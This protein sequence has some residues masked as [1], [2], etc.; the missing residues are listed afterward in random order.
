MEIT[1]ECLRL[2]RVC[3]VEFFSVNVK[4]PSWNACSNKQKVRLQLDRIVYQTYTN[5]V[6]QI[7]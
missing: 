6:V 1:L 4:Y 5:E 3:A 2:F 7:K